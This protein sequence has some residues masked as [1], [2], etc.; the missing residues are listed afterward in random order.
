MV[1]A[2]SVRARKRSWPLHRMNAWVM[3]QIGKSPVIVGYHI[4]VP[5]KLELGVVIEGENERKPTKKD[6][7]RVLQH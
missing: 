7:L 3:L 4:R 6:W 1:E 5:S 2:R